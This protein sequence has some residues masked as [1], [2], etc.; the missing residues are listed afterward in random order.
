MTE[1]EKLENIKQEYVPEE[2]LV[3]SYKNKRIV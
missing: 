3:D 2:N 1:E